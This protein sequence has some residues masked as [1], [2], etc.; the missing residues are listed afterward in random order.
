MDT[1]I[2]YPWIGEMF[3]CINRGTVDYSWIAI[4]QN[5]TMHG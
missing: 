1:G 3:I 5:S 2:E 4:M